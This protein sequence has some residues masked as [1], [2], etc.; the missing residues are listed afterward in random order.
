MK[1]SSP[2]GHGFAA[3]R[4]NNLIDVLKGNRAIVIGDNNAKN[5]AD[6]IIINRKGTI[7]IQ[8]KYYED[9]VRAINECFDSE[10]GLLRYVDA[11]GNPMQI[12]VPCDQYEKAIT[13]YRKQKQSRR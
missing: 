10:T 1:F 7:L 11:N 5:G 2:T 9:P 4:G 12:E 6:R 3:E 13:E 8:D